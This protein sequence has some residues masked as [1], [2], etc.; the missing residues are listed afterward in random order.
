MALG[1]HSKVLIGWTAVTAGAL[2]AFYFSRKSV[3]HKR[4]LLMTEERR[5]LKEEREA[6]Q[7]LSEKS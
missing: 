1:Q 6:A 7:K 3:N 5:K 4:F 2:T